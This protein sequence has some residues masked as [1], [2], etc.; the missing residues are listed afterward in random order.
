MK[1]LEK[2]AIGLAGLQ[3]A[4]LLFVIAA[5]IALGG[6][7]RV[8]QWYSMFLDAASII[9][10]AAVYLMI[11]AA[12]IRRHLLTQRARRVQ[13]PAPDSSLRKSA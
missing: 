3:L 10:I 5:N 13:Q 12:A 8:N 6:T 11:E 2:I 1:L 4:K 9:A 7:L